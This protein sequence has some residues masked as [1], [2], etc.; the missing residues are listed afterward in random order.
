MVSSSTSYD[1][2]S[3]DSSLIIER[4][5]DADEDLD[6]SNYNGDIESSKSRRGR[7]KKNDVVIETPFGITIRGKHQ[8]RA[9]VQTLAL[10]ALLAGCGV[11]HVYSAAMG[12]DDDGSELRRL[13]EEEICTAQTADTWWS[14]M[15]YILG[16]LYTFLALA[17]V[18]DEF[19]VPALEELSGPHKMNLSMDVAGATLMAAGGS[20]PELATSLIGTFK[21]SEI[22]FGTIVGSAVFNILFVIGMCSLLAKEVLTLTWWPLFRDSTYYTIG[23]VVLAIF[24][25]VSSPNEVQLW[26]SCILFAMYIGYCLLMWK[27][28]E[29]YMKLTGK[30][31]EYPDEDGEDDEHEATNGNAKEEDAEERKESSDDKPELKKQPSDKSN[32]SAVSSGL[33]GSEHSKA[34]PHFLWQGNFRAGIL[35]LLKNP[36]SWADTAGTGMVAKIIGDADHVFE[37]VDKDGNGHIDGDELQ[38]LFELLECHATT[39][40]LREVFQELDTN[41]DGVI[42]HKEFTEWYC[43]SEERILQQVRHVFDQIDVDNSNSIDKDELKT[44]LATLDPHVTDEDVDSA[45]QEMYNH[46]DPDEITFDEFSS[47]YKSSMLFERQQQMI[48]E[49]IEGVWENISPPM[50]GGL[51]DWVWYL[52]CLPLVLVLTITIPD[53]QR[54]GNSKWCVVSFFL[55]IAWIGGF[56]YFMVDWAEIVGNTFGIPDELMGLTVLAAGTSVPDLLSSVIVARRGQGDMAVSSSVGSN[57]FD[58]LVGLPV[59]WIIYSAVNKA[60]PVEIGAEGLLRSLLILIGMLV[61]VITSVHFQGWR[62]TKV[63]GGIMFLFYIGFLVQAI[64]FELPFQPVC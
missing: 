4:N 64:V 60:K 37:T 23:L 1:A 59:P 55:S 54:P 14:L 53:V 2:E 20:A 63:L 12:S 62:L 61:L 8:L 41:G 21:E 25:G 10:G 13:E 49:D 58:I 57:I 17:I 46:G 40:E 9:A 16:I 35:K 6:N 11:F 19:F 5:P 45:L 33:N 27:N 52:V 42:S 22:G 44:L 7:N 29:L 3:I 34:F 48:D 31:L 30:T 36:D 26:E 51:R 38:Q 50:G 47:W 56:S 18:C 32:K 39:E 15:L 43:K 24:T 28:Q